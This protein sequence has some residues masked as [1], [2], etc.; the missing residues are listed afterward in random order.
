MAAGALKLAGQRRETRLV[1][2]PQR[3]C[4]TIAGQAARAGRADS[5][6]GAGDHHDA[7]G[8]SK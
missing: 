8:Q 1:H 7:P 3:D 6:C 2:V 4:R 5:L